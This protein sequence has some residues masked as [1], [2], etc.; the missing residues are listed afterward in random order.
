MSQWTH[1]AGVIRLDGGGPIIGMSHHDEEKLISEI[2]ASS[3]L[4]SGSEGPIEYSFQHHGQDST[5]GVHIASSSAYRGTISIWGDLRDYGKS[6]E[7]VDKIIDWFAWLKN[8]LNGTRETPFWFREG[9]L[10]IDVE[11]AKEKIILVDDGENGLVKVK[12]E[13]KHD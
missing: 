11:Y 9:M 1:V 2:L 13:K 8:R 3:P 10:V 5:C 4:P 6:Q 7:E 12:A